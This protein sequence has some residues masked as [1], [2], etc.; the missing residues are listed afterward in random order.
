MCCGGVLNRW[1][2]IVFY[3][4]L[5]CA[6]HEHIGQGY[7]L[8]IRGTTG[9]GSQR[10]HE[11]VHVMMKHQPQYWK[12]CLCER[13]LVAPHHKVDQSYH[14]HR[15]LSMNIEQSELRSV[16]R[17]GWCCPGIIPGLCCPGWCCPCCHNSVRSPGIWPMLV[18]RP[19]PIPNNVELYNVTLWQ[20]LSALE[21]RSVHITGLVS[22]RF[23]SHLQCTTYWAEPATDA[24]RHW[25]HIIDLTG[26]LCPLPSLHVMRLLPVPI[27]SHH[28]IMNGLAHK[29]PRVLSN[30][31]ISHA[32]WNRADHPRAT[33]T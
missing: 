18:V 32:L 9:D 19:R 8:V 22:Y 11:H 21:P 12:V 29:T 13:L 10:V 30:P 1:C 3:M 5:S 2:Y 27:P 4:W 33:L 14:V 23:V 25:H 20:S 28:C 6:R 15:T 17:P 16:F 31:K 7:G 24:S 26:G